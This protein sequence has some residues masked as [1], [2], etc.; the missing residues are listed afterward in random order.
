MAN[1]HG[2]KLSRKMEAAVAALLISPTV[3]AAA[4]QAGVSDR[5]LRTWL[6][7]PAFKEAFRQARRRLVDTAVLLLQHA[8]QRAVHTL[9]KELEG[10]KASDRIRAAVALLDQCFRGLEALDLAESMAEL[11]ELVEG[12]GGH[13]HGGADAGAGP[14]EGGAADAPA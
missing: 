5:T 10:A 11:R 3:E 2:E 12:R 1:G 8:S 13:V 9:V 4:A 14:A 7:Q 6:K